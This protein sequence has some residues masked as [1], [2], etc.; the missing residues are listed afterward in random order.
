MNTITSIEQLRK[1]MEVCELKQARAETALKEEL[2]LVVKNIQPINLIKNTLSKFS[3]TSDLKEKLVDST[4]G[5]VSGFLL[6][7]LVVRGSHNP[8]KQI[9]GTLLQ[10]G[11]SAM[12]SN[13]SK[14]LFSI[15]K[16]LIKTSK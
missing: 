1:E 11:V 6:N 16:R 7:K 14:I 15:G 3:G 12:I 9:L 2:N 13:K 4:L 5:T 8:L 10:I